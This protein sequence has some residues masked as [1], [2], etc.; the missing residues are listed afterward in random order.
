MI[1]EQIRSKDGETIIVELEDKRKLYLSIEVVLKNG[2]R[3]GDNL[4]EDLFNYLIR[5]NQKY[6]VRKKALDLL[7]RRAHSTFELKIK[8]MQRKYER[9]L[10][11]ELLRELT[12][13]NF[14]NDKDFAL[15]YVNERILLRKSGKQKLKA[16]LIKK[17]IHQEIITEVISNLDIAEDF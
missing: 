7:A 8:L 14:L 3:K 9:E 1:I 2:L 11:E 17:G 16:E 10:I 5:E 15:Q 12:T 4:D 6:F 13:K